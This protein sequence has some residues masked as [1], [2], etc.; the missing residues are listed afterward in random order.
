MS[1]PGDHGGWKRVLDLLEL[2]FGTV[3]SHHVGAGS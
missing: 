1:V 3:V 2:E